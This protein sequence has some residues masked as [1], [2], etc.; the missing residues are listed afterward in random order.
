[1]QKKDE[2]ESQLLDLARVTRVTAGGKRLRFRATIIVGNR[3][4][5]IGVGVAK[6]KDV[7][8]AIEKATRQAKKN[9]IEVPI[10]N[11]TI[12]FEVEKKYKSAKVLLRPQKKGRGIIAGGAMRSICELAGIPN[13]TGKLLSKT[14]NKINIARATIKALQSLQV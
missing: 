14:N 6:G 13:I 10:K 11:E 8:E 1:M 3:N 7:S 12:P 9:L 4:G 5:K 2:F